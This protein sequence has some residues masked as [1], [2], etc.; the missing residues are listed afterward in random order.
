LTAFIAGLLISVAGLALLYS[1]EPASRIAGALLAAAGVVFVFSSPADP[2]ASMFLLA[3][4]A[5]VATLI[6]GSQWFRRSRPERTGKMGGP[7]EPL[8]PTGPA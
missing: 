8:Q 4:V 5:V 2:M 7:N 3:L 1:R 6:F